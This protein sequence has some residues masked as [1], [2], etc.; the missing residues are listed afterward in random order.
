[1]HCGRR[2]DVGTSM[3]GPVGVSCTDGQPWFSN[4]NQGA[5]SMSLRAVKSYCPSPKLPV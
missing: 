5:G 2:Q 3:E 4:S 1:M